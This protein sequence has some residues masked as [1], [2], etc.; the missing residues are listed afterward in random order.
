MQSLRGAAGG[1]TLAFDRTTHALQRAFQDPSL[2]SEGPAEVPDGVLFLGGHDDG[3]IYLFRRDGTVTLVAKA[4]SGRTLKEPF[5]DRSNGNALVWEEATRVAG[6][7]AKDYV[8]WT[9]PYATRLAD[10]KPRA[11]ARIPGDDTGR[12]MAVNAGMALFK[13]DE[14]TGL[15]VRLSDGRGWHIPTEPD[16]H[17]FTPLWVD[18]NYVWFITGSQYANNPDGILRIERSTLG[19]PTLPSGL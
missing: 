4:P 8:L 5:V 14:R 16:H 2:Y 6:P 10:L 1:H 3:D 11:V 7:W 18:D 13:L 9:S 15:L 17:L 12:A 19:P